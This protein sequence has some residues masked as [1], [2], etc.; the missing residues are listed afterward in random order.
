[1][2]F[3]FFLFLFFIFS[4][5][6]LCDDR[7]TIAEVKGPITPVTAQ[8]IKR[9]IERAEDK[10]SDY[11]I[12]T[13]DT[14]GGLD[15]SMREIVK[16]ML[17][18]KVKTI[19]F[20]YPQGARCAS[21]CLFI[22]VAGNSACMASTTNVGSAHPV[23]IGEKQDKIMVK[24][25]TEDAVAF[26]VSVAK[27][28]NHYDPVLV[29]M[30]RES[31]SLTAKEALSRGIIDCIADN[32]DEL[33]ENLNI[34]PLQVMKVKPNFLEKFLSFITHPTVAYF[35]LIFGFYG[36]LFE[37]YNPGSILPGVVGSFCL[38]L[39]L[40]AFHILPVNWAG[41][42][43]IVLAFVL[44]IL[45]VKVQSH[46]LLGIAGALF[47]IFGSLMMFS[48]FPEEYRPSLFSVAFVVVLTV[49][50]FFFVVIMGVRALKRKP[51]SG[52]EALVG[53]R[54][55]A[56]T[57]INRNGGWAFVR[58][59]LWKAV[60]DE[61]IKEGEEVLVVEVDGLS[62]IVKRINSSEK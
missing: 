19:T 51:V 50:F 52:K 5:Y 56:R 31:K 43:L 33:Y 40:Y 13:L 23:M 20:V 16:A 6:A 17:S 8:Y 3:L 2:R 25:V 55:V 62:L 18:S 21:A 37:L 48:N 44:F 15:E 12:I 60:S 59:E 1:M 28:R 45:E 26:L 27:S 4:G 34:K 24:K 38:V 41:L 14:P 35:L 53:M 36:I 22:L 7:I 29:S 9:V 49:I 54:G 11:L 42:L 61:E 57:T 39:A 46:G 47:I 58:G 32:F 30:V 10:R